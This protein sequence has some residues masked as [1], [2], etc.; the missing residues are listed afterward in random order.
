MHRSKLKSLLQALSTHEKDPLIKQKIDEILFELENIPDEVI[1]PDKF[2]KTFVKKVM[3]VISW[4]F[5][6]S[7]E[8]EFFAWVLRHFL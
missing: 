2:Q 7:A 6:K 8:H 4:F 5:I 1:S 3:D